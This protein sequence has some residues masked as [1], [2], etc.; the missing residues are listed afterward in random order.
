MNKKVLKHRNILFT[1]KTGFG[2]MTLFM[3][4]FLKYKRMQKC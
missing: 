2:S 4:E 1:V 3:W